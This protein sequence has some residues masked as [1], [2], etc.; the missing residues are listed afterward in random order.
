MLKFIKFVLLLHGLPDVVF[1]ST[2]TV[3]NYQHPIYQT[4][5]TLAYQGHCQSNVWSMFSGSVDGK[6]ALQRLRFLSL[7]SGMYLMCFTPDTRRWQARIW[8][9]YSSFCC[10]YGSCQVTGKLLMMK[11]NYSVSALS[12]FTVFV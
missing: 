7:A 3:V 10:F 11:S 1:I 4:E 8:R 5:T 2:W 12:F 6:C 9:T